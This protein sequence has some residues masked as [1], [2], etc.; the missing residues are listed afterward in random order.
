MPYLFNKYYPLRDILFFLGEGAMIFFS[1]LSSCLIFVGMNEFISQIGLYCTQA[2]VVTAV[3]QLCLYFFD[4]YEMRQD[5]N[6]LD[7]AIRLT[8]AFG[9]GCIVL[10][11]LYYLLPPLLIHSRIFWAG[12]VLVSFSLLIYRYFYHKGLIY[13]VCDYYKRHRKVRRLLYA[14]ISNF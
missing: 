8:Q 6:M 4:M 11:V 3:F 10:G 7:N 13:T 5:L 2:I 12:Y 9:V 1:I 14:H